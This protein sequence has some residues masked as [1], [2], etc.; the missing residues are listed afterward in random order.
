MYDIEATLL[1][2]EDVFGDSVENKKS[3]I[4][5]KIGTKCKLTDFAIILG[6]ESVEFF[7]GK[8]YGL[9][10]TTSSDRRGN[11]ICVN[12][13]YKL[14]P[15]SYRYIG[16]RPVLN[17]NNKDEFDNILNK[18]SVTENGHLIVELGNYAFNVVNSELSSKLDN[19][20]F[21]Y[22]LTR[23][24]SKKFKKNC[25]KITVDSVKPNDKYSSFKPLKYPVVEY[26]GK[27]YVKVKS[28]SEPLLIRILSNGEESVTDNYYWL[29]ISPFI[30]YVDKDNKRLISKDLIASGIRFGDIGYYT[31]DFAKAEMYEWLNKYFKEELFQWQELNKEHKK[32]PEKSINEKSE[33]INII[34]RKIKELIPA[35]FGND[36]IMSKINNLITK[37]NSDIKNIYNSNGL[38]TN[39]MDKDYLYN[40]LVNDLEEI[41]SVLKQSFL[42]YKDYID[43]LNYVKEC[44]NLL[45]SDE[46]IKE[47]NDE[48]QKDI[49]TI[50]SVIIPFL[51]NNN[52]FLKLKEIFEIEEN[53]IF[54][55][56]KNNGES[57]NYKTKAEFILYIRNKLQEYLL[58]ISKEVNNKSLIL[59]LQEGYLKIMASNFTKSKDDYVN[60][61]L[62][63]LNNIIALIN[64][65]GTFEE[66]DKLDKLLNENALT[67]VD[68]MVSLENFSLVYK[69]VY[70]IYLDIIDRENKLEEIDD[71]TIKI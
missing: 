61:L 39:I 14:Y 63:E 65:K 67:N 24:N 12:G 55:Y 50:K 46:E 17:F 10:C 43:I 64:E 60:N 21:V 68:A 27:R 3:S 48:L 35:Y 22:D 37:Y 1:S 30:W 51:D 32:D 54:N 13:N 38:T 33:K 49:L 8:Y 40:K 31:G 41:L 5:E 16:I 57:P 45:N 18:A 15:A 56:L 66:K 2:S 6:A 20:E 59:E 44:L 7:N 23:I 71:Y 34:V 69:K 62:N 25:G 42:K 4:I 29:E 26:N 53:N 58:N 9:W 70:C 47:N 11:I 36:D 52:W 28:K 19:Y